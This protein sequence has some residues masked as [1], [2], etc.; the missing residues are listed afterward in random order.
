MKALFKGLHLYWSFLT[1]SGNLNFLSS[2]DSA[3]YLEFKSS[4]GVKMKP[5]AIK[6]QSRTYPPCYTWS[7]FQRLEPSEAPIP[8][9]DPASEELSSSCAGCQHLP[10]PQVLPEARAQETKKPKEQETLSQV[11]EFQPVFCLKV[12]SHNPMYEGASGFTKVHQ[13]P[14]FLSAPHCL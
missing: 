4:S 6:K 13:C 14:P 1:E 3:N 9:R 5:A 10:V 8:R 7:E 11:Y 2:M 12:L